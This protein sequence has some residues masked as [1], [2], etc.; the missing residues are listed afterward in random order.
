MVMPPDIATTSTSAQASRRVA[1]APAAFSPPLAHQ[2]RARLE[3]A[4]GP[5]LCYE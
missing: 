2:V 4:R 3:L 1:M 5:Q